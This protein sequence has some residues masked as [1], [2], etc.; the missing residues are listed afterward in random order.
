L[1]YFP[2][3]AGARQCI[4][5]GFAWIEGILV[6]ATLAQQWPMQL[7]PGYPVILRPLIT[8]RPKY[9]MRLILT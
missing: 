4:G 9:G 7:V 1:A 3:G 5:K 8:P 2:F 6:L